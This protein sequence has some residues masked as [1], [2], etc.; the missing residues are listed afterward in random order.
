MVNSHFTKEE[1]AN[2]LGNKIQTR[3]AFSGIP[4]GTTGTVTAMYN[5]GGSD[6]GVDIT[7]T[8]KNRKGKPPLVD[9]FSKTEYESFLTVIP[10]GVSDVNVRN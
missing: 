3:M 6:W 4:A 9:G 1:A 8:L 2:V 7:W 5:A 10:T